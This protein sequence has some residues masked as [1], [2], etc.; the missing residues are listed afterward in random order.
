MVKG[1]PIKLDN[2]PLYVSSV[3]KTKSKNVSGTYYVYDGKEYTGNRY[4]ICSK[5]EY[6][7]KG[8]SYILGYIDLDDVK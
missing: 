5:K 8:T 6:V 2:T 3:I 1:Q 7:G 4:R